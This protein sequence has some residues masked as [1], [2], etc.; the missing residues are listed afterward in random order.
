MELSRLDSKKYQPILK[1][2]RQLSNS[3][4]EHTLPENTTTSNKQ[5][6]EYGEL[7]VNRLSQIRKEYSENDLK[8]M[9]ALYRFGKTTRELGEIFKVSKTTI[10]KLLREQGVEVTRSKVQA[11]LNA[12]EIISMYKN[13]Y[14]AERIAKQ[15]DVCPQAILDCLRNHGVKIK[16]RWDYEQK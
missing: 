15:F 13:G 7:A 2:K 1:F 10:T 8:E 3:P 14:T 12:E 5:I 11:R 6:D 16:S 9:A 4:Y